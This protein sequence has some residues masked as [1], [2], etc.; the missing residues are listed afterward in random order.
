MGSK[1]CWSKVDLTSRLSR[2]RMVLLFDCDTFRYMANSRYLYYMDLIRYEI[3]FRSPLYKNTVK[4][5]IYA[6]LGSQKIIYKK[7]LKMWATFTISLVLDGWDDKWVYHRQT[8]TRNDEVYAIGFTKIAFWQNNKAQ[9]VGRILKDCGV[10]ITEMEISPELR[11]VFED[12]HDCLKRI[13]KSTN[14]I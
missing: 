9:D 6:V 5:G 4:K 7:P 3:M 12:D 8:F 13:S 1:L 11:A 2:K 10:S 14:E